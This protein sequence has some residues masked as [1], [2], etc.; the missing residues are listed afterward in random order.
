MYSFSL[1]FVS[2]CFFSHNYSE[3]SEILISRALS[4]AKPLDLYVDDDRQYCIAIFDDDELEFAIGRGGVNVNLAANATEYRID[5]F[6]KKEYEQKLTE[7]ETPL[8]NIQNMPVR[9][10]KPLADN[11]VSTVSELLN[12][13][14]ER[15]LEIKGIAEATLEKIY[16]AVQSFVEANQV[17]EK[18]EEKTLAKFS[19]SDNIKVNS[20][21]EQNPDEKI[22]KKPPE[23]E[24]SNEPLSETNA[25]QSSEDKLEKVQS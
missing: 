19:D 25:K 11:G 5:A 21:S 8:A 18:N 3:K 13:E 17:E 7:K 1:I 20:K 15:L 9:A 2:L 22:T 12:S 23:K 4:P 24:I 16:S 14:E 6:G 10:V